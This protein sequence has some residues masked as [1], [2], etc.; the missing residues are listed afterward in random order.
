M[1]E[2]VFLNPVTDDELLTIVHKCKSKASIGYGGIDM[3]LVKK[4][5]RLY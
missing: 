5:F 4:L 2:T 3:N 1:E